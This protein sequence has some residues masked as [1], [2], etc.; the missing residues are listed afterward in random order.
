VKHPAEFY[1]K[2]LLI[3]DPQV[4]DAQLLKKISDWGILSPDEK[5]LGFLRQR[6]PAPPPGFDPLNFSDRPSMRYLREQGVYEIFHSTPGMNEAWDLMADPE[7][8]L[9]VEQAILSR[10]DLKMLAQKLNKKNG[11][12]LTEDGISTFRHYFWNLKLLTFDEW[13]RNLWSR[14]ALY[15]TYMGLLRADSK[16]SFSLLRIEQSIE[17]KNMIRRAQ[18]IAYYTLEEVNL[19]PGTPPDKVKAISVLNKSI[20]ECHEALST[21]DMALKDV[22]KQFERWRMEGS[23]VQPRDVHELAPNGN[24]TN[25]GAGSKDPKP[26]PN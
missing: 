16:L 2:Y 15:E 1:M 7:K 5:Y 17:S 11:W 12:F 13:G 20:V 21:S 26:L 24:F 6:I 22:L 19:K 4:L 8:R 23:P 10:L 3:Q 14:T 9:I 25:G 18:E